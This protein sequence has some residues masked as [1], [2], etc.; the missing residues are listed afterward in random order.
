MLQEGKPRSITSLCLAE[1]QLPRK[2]DTH[3][4]PRAWA[5][6]SLPLHRAQEQTEL[7][8]AL[9]QP[10]PLRSDMSCSSARPHSL[11]LQAAVSANRPL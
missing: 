10:Q 5:Q 8:W 11:T 3:L 9:G 7:V 4:T 2:T 6:L 1:S